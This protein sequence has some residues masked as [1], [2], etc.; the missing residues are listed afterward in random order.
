MCLEIKGLT[1]KDSCV[2]IFD[3]SFRKWFPTFLFI[4]NNLYLFIS[5]RPIKNILKPFLHFLGY[6]F[7]TLLITTRERGE[8]VREREHRE[9]GRRSRD[10]PWLPGPTW[11]PSAGRLPT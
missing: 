8:W 3:F 7:A 10:D 2:A 11:Q 4:I 6:D 1:S 5:F 9:K